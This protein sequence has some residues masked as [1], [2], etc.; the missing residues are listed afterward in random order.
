MDGKYMESIWIVVGFTWLYH[1]K[2]K[3][4]LTTP[5]PTEQ[6]GDRQRQ[7]GL[8]R[9][10]GVA[11]PVPGRWKIIMDHMWIIWLS[12]GFPMIFPFSYGFS[13]WL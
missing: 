5:V 1:T 4:S 13:I 3:T 9:P 6:Q 8:P 12:Y 10:R 11:L 2:K 7:C